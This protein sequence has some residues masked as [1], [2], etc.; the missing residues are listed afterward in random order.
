MVALEDAFQTR[1]DEGAFAEARDLGQ[2]RALVERGVGERRARRRAGRLSR[3]GTDRW[4]ARAIR[5]VE[6]A[7]VDP[8]ARARV[9]VDARRGARAPARLDGA[10]DLRRQ[11]SEPHGRAGDPGGAAARAGGTASRRRWRRNSSRRISFP[12]QYGRARVVHQ[13]PELLPGRAVLQRVSAAAARSRRAADA[14]LHRRGARG[15]LLGAD[16]SRRASAR[17]PARSIASARASG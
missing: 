13:Q 10:G 12:R 8:A 11:P 4:L 7:D 6:P 15:R 1:L 14:A 17:R 2:L 3:R 16:L 5:R 9:R